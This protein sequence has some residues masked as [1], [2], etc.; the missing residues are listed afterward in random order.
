MTAPRLVATDLDGTLLRSDGTVSART[1]AVLLE[2]DRRD[3][4]VVFVT[5][6]PI[7]WVHELRSLVGGRGLVICSNGAALLDLPRDE[8]LLA[9]TIPAALVRESVAAIRRA[10]PGAGFALDG[11][12]GF[13]KEADFLERTPAPP[14]SP[15]GPIELVIR[16]DDVLKLLTR[17]ETMP[18]ERFRALVT[19]A[20]P[21]LEVTASDLSGLVEISAPG[22]TKAT[23]LTLVCER[24]G[25]DAAEVVAFGDMPNDLPMLAWAGRSF[26]MRE[27]HPSVVATATDRAASN[28]DDGVAQVLEELF[29]L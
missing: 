10:V 13:A 19:A 18:A 14:G 12:H 1:A 27:A 11:L 9:R 20:V 26:A 7:R 2:L 8:V 21:E 15:V 28:D 3:V 22:V 5:A 17:H 23:G 4:P 24:F 16:D 25:I 29:G 6:R